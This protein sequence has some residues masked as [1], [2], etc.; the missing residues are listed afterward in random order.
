MKG[1]AGRLEKQQK[2]PP[3]PG[4]LS[5]GGGDGVGSLRSNI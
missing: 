4:L 5:G 1:F 3:P 2:G